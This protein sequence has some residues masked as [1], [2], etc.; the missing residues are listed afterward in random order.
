MAIELGDPEIGKPIPFDLDYDLLSKE[1]RTLEPLSSDEFVRKLT[2]GNMD[3]PVCDY[4]TQQGVHHEL[5]IKDFDT[6]EKGDF[7][8]IITEDGTLIMRDR[9]Q[10]VS[11]DDVL[12]IE[13]PICP[14]FKC[15]SA[16]NPVDECS[17]GGLCIEDYR[18]HK[19][20]HYYLTNN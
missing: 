15:L 8:Y 18:D 10:K 19:N 5:T 3:V 4:F 16:G 20:C 2:V 6:D 11:K 17:L 14:N 13:P 9:S 12:S 1:D 7:I